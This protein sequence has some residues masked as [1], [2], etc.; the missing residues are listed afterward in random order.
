LDNRKGDCAV[1]DGATSSAVISIA[2]STAS[3]RT[4]LM[5]DNLI[6]SAA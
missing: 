3:E 5:L 2:S 1:A 4:L 6:R